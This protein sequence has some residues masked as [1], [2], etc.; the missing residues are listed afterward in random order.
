MQLLKNRK[1]KNIFQKVHKIQLDH[2]AEGETT[3]IL[4]SQTVREIPFGNLPPKMGGEIQTVSPEAFK[5]Q[6]GISWQEGMEGN[7]HIS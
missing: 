3:T 2:F 5:N 4:P 1:T 6:F 7:P